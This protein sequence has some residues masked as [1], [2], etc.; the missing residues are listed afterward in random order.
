[1]TPAVLCG[2]PETPAREVAEQLARLKVHQQYVADQ[3]GVL[4]GVTSTLDFLRHLHP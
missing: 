3:A 2:R 1:M 4:V